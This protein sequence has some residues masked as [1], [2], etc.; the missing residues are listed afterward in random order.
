M[1]LFRFAPSPTGYLHVGNARIAM[2][3]YLFAK[4]LNG[5]F[6]LRIDDTDHQRNRPE[7]EQ[8][9]Y[10]GLNWL[11]LHWDCF[12][13]Q[14]DRIARY[15]AARDRLIEMGRLYPC[16]ESEE[17]LSLKRKMQASRGLP[18]VYDRAALNLSAAQIAQKQAAGEQPH[19]RFKLSGNPIGFD[20]I[21][22]GSIHFGGGHLSDPVL[23]RADG[24]VLYT[25]SSVV[26]DGE[27]NATHILR[28][29]DHVTNT[30]VQ[31]ELFEALGFTPPHFIHLPL[32][33]GSDGEKLSKRIGGLSLK[34]LEADGYEAAAL[35]AHLARLG[36]SEAA[37]GTETLDE[38]IKG[39][40][41]SAFGKAAPRFDLAQ[42]DSVNQNSVAAL[43]YEDAQPRLEKLGISKPLWE[44]VQGNL[45]KLADAAHWVLV[46]NAA[47][48]RPDFTAEDADYLKQAAQ[49]LPAA[50]RFNPQDQAARDALYDDWVKAIKAATGRKG[51]PLFLPLRLALTGLNHGPKMQDLLPLIGYEHCKKALAQ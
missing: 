42:L 29:E 48:H 41:I 13:R 50:A 24:R 23:I 46:C 10:D 2:L 51:K 17:E 20:D 9:I 19:W 5:K 11:G 45:T 44:T 37:K 38:L 21:A 18:P 30:A 31:V 14:S 6:M 1:V 4:S 47:H 25:L 15:D 22:R 36:S 40:D 34:E 16:F 12:A 27:L 35:N 33:L 32:M 28:G 7:Y 43:S 39:F 26:D 49:C 8:A 3:N